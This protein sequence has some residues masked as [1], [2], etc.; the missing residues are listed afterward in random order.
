MP[1]PAN[2]IEPHDHA[3]TSWQLSLRFDE[4]TAFREEFE[5]NIAAGAT[6]VATPESYLPKQAVGITLDLAFCRKR[7]CF[8]AVVVAVV[9]PA[10]A[11]LANS[12]AGVSVRFLDSSSE[13]KDRLEA[14]TGID[15][16]TGALRNRSE[17]RARARSRSDSDIV[18]TTP[19]ETFSGTTANISYAGVLAML[20]MTSIPAGTE[21]RVELS[22]PMVELDLTV[23]GRI[24]HSR[25]CDGGM[26]AHGI[27][28]QYPAERIDEVMAFIEFL[29]SFD[30]ARR[31]AIVSGSI[32]AGGLCAILDLFAQTAPA[33]TLA[34]TNGEENGRIVFSENYLLLCTAGMASG[35]KALARL[36]LWTDGRFEFH[37]DLQLA[38][39]PDDPQPLEAAMMTASVQIDELR[40][41]GLD[42]FQ[43]DDTFSLATDVDPGVREKLSETEAEVLDYVGDGFSIGVICDMVA[44]LDADI[45]KA[46]VALLDQGAIH[47]PE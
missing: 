27:Q 45:Y 8:P 2:Q 47:R 1:R 9:E 41:I 15:L 10:L 25:R 17:R 31:L 20:P 34:V 33:G 13:L 21:V 12:A 28:L 3:S 14:V 5:S 46:L 4:A 16:S 24:I 42:T 32:D 29:Q 11:D 30:R 26:I 18:L 38:D 35:L 40:R 7:I 6:F 36:F 19:T 23:D 39:S 22:N 37:H 43:F 44:A